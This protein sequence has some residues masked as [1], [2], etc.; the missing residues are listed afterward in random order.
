MPMRRRSIRRLPKSRQ[1]RLRE[2][3]RLWAVGQRWD[4]W[5]Y[6]SGRHGLPTTYNAALRPIL[7]ETANDNHKYVVIRMSRYASRAR[8]RTRPR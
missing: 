1:R 5:G 6:R 4:A 7:A 8:T 3:V 2:A